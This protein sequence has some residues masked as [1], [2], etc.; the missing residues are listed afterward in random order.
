MPAPANKSTGQLY[1]LNH[2]A[3]W[4]KVILLVIVIGDADISS[5]FNGSLT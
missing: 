1:Q 5:V 2:G 4:S 3:D